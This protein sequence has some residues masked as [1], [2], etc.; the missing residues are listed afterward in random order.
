[1]QGT[2][3]SLVNPGVSSKDPEVAAILAGRPTPASERIA[4]HTG[5]TE[6]ISVEDVPE[7]FSI[8]D[9]DGVVFSTETFGSVNVQLYAQD[10]GNGRSVLGWFSPDETEAFAANLVQVASIARANKVVAR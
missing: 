3:R 7:V 2:D 9:A 6:H 10:P 1:M 5:N 4:E 8:R